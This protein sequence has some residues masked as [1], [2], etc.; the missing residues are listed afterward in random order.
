MLI[1]TD[2]F[3]DSEKV[4]H[5]DYVRGLLAM[6][7]ITFRQVGKT[8]GVTHSC[9]SHVLYGRGKSRR[10]LQAVA[11]VLHIPFDKLWGSKASFIRK[12]RVSQ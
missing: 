10:V 1:H 2:E 12:R 3:I 8:I 9:V 5:L 7:R 11:D 6:N 4:T